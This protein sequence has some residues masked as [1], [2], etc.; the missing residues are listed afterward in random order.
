[1]SL[2]LLPSLPPEK[3]AFPVPTAPSF[4]FKRRKQ[5]GDGVR[6]E[7]W[8]FDVWLMRGRDGTNLCHRHEGGFQPTLASAKA[9]AREYAQL[10]DFAYSEWK[11]PPPPTAAELRQQ[12]VRSTIRSV[13]AWDRRSIAAEGGSGAAMHE[14][15]GLPDVPADSRASPLSAARNWMVSAE[16]CIELAQLQPGRADNY[17]RA[18]IHRIAAAI[19]NLERKQTE[20]ATVRPGHGLLVLT[21]DGEG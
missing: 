12:K 3:A 2:R 10:H 11:E 17:A 19:R 1:M 21:Q 20:L 13:H 18:A 8:G 9:W 14:L 15:P 5:R 6:G 4:A 7:L 16:A